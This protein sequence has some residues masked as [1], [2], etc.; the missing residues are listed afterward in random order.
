MITIEKIQLIRNE[1]STPG[2][3]VFFPLLF[4]LCYLG[5]SLYF[6]EFLYSFNG[7]LLIEQF[8]LTALLLYF[9]NG[10]IKELVSISGRVSYESRKSLVEVLPSSMT[11]WIR[12]KSIALLVGAL[13]TTWIRDFIPFKVWVVLVVCI[14]VLLFMKGLKGI[15][16]QYRFNKMIKPAPMH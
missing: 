6:V 2:Y 4:S 11:N 13:L 15:Q 5:F 10:E 3:L 16:G 1:H 12:Y 7:V 8:I 9:T 14:S